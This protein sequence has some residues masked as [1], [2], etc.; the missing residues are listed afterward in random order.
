MSTITVP[1]PVQQR[2]RIRVVQAGVVVIAAMLLFC[3]PV[4]DETYAVHEFFELAGLALALA[5]IFGRLWSILYVGGKKNVELV[6]WGP[7]SMTRN[8]LYFS[9][10]VGAVGV[11]LMFGSILAALVL[12]TATFVIFAVTASREAVFLRAKFGSA[13]DAYARRT[14][15]FWPNPMR[16]S[17]VSRESFAP[18]VLKRTFADS[19]YFLGVFPALETVEYLHLYGVLPT[20]L[21]LY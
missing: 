13:Y 18:E 12:G 9:S 1:R 19:L 8:P 10:T 16:Y 20:L 2:K 5:C 14:P 4:W 6:M 15:L 21:R 3:N 17:D 7:Y 11:G